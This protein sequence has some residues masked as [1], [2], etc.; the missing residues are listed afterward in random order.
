MALGAAF[1]EI[2]P[3]TDSQVSVVHAGPNPNQRREQAAADEGEGIVS[4]P[5]IPQDL[6]LGVDV[7]ERGIFHKLRSGIDFDAD[8]PP[9]YAYQCDHQQ[10]N[11]QQN[12]DNQ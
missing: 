12:Q 8:M 2:I 4:G 6:C 9:S 7:V 3:Q 1:A 11:P 10:D 5:I